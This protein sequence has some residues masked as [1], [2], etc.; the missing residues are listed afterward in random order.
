MTTREDIIT[1][2]RELVQTR[3]YPGFSFQDIADRVGIRKASLYHH[4][5]SKEALAE[6][7]L[8]EARADLRKAL[9][10]VA[11]ED[12]PAQLQT[13]FRI[14]RDL[15]Q[16]GQRVCP[17]GA[18]VPGWGIVPER[19][20]QEVVGLA[21]DQARW[22]TSLIERGREQAYFA[23]LPGPAE[24]VALWIFST[25]QGALLSARA[26]GRKADFDRVVAQL[27]AALLPG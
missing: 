13:Y 8:K 4:F 2:A 24:D 25:L 12:I 16:A 21:R 6:A 23:H 20:H 17:G 26:S 9:D 15:L 7:V 19:L 27:Q 3:S 1:V 11:G 14:Y 5:R 18:F 10:G 22:L